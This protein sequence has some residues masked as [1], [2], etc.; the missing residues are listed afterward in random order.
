MAAGDGDGVQTSPAAKPY[1]LFMGAD[2]LVEKDQQ[3]LR[4]RDVSGGSV[5]VDT[6][7]GPVFIVVDRGKVAF[8][9]DPV[10]KLSATTAA[11]DGLKYERAYT[12]GHDPV[13]KFMREQAAAGSLAQSSA[14]VVNQQ[15]AQAALSLARQAGGA[16]PARFDRFDTPEK[17]MIYTLERAT[18][19]LDTRTN[20][21]FAAESGQFNQVSTYANRLQKELAQELF[22]AVE[23]TFEVSAEKPLNRPYLVLFATF[24]EAKAPVGQMRRWIYARELSPIDQTARTVHFVQGGF[25]EGFELK[26]LQVRL[27]NAGREVAT[28]LSPKRVPLTVDEAFQYVM[29]D[30]LAAHK[31]DTL[32]AKPVLTLLPPDVQE[33]VAKRGAKQLLFARISK[34]GRVT[35]VCLDEDCT[36]KLAD[37]RLQAALADVRY[38]PA[39]ERGKP[40]DSVVRLK[41]AD[42]SQT[43]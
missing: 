19:M 39:L 15:F 43:L 38:K 6:K 22:D 7:R 18:A 31:N 30:Y 34:E 35:E 20:A 42:L 14:A 37:S 32:P 12:P 28:N 41:V 4:V 10:L 17:K 11:V 16:P 1:T 40:V 33:Q 2:V 13:R 26:E 9:L 27:Y 3:M 29:L 24:R 23:V 8:K 25:P 36:A 21:A 5:V